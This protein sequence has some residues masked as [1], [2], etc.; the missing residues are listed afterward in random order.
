MAA[1]PG[2][3]GAMSRRRRRPG[4]RVLVAAVVAV[5][6]G[7]GVAAAASVS[8]SPSLPPIAPDR[9]IASVLRS[10]SSQ[11][12][13][14][15]QLATHVDLGLPDIPAQF[16]QLDAGG[17]ARLVSAISGDH[18]VR[19]WSSKDGYRLAELLP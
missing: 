4:A 18:R 16:Q 19:L 6:V 14:S 2:D 9:L 10:L 17:V 1:T 12:A 8:S 11:P 7:G 15:G 13:V 5:A 3:E